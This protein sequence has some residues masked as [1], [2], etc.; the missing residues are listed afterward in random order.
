MSWGTHL[1]LGL[2]G[3][4]IDPRRIEFEKHSLTKAVEV[5]FFC[6]EYQRHDSPSPQKPCCEESSS[7]NILQ[8]GFGEFCENKLPHWWHFTR[9]L[10]LVEDLVVWILLEERLVVVRA[11]TF[12]P[13]SESVSSP[14]QKSDVQIQAVILLDSTGDGEH[15]SEGSTG[16]SMLPRRMLVGKHSLMT[17]VI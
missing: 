13:F 6:H 4:S 15:S 10:L 5:G 11:V 9:L 1:S 17:A 2:N 16:S 3:L 14:L 8:S 7:S 12:L